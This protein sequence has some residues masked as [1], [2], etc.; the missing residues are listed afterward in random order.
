MNRLKTR[1]GTTYQSETQETIKEKWQNKYTRNQYFGVR[2]SGRNSEPWIV[3]LCQGRQ[4]AS[5]TLPT[6]LC[7]GGPFTSVLYGRQQTN[8]DFPSQ[9]EESQSCSSW[10]DAAHSQLECD[11]GGGGLQQAKTGVQ[12]GGVTLFRLMCTSRVAH[13]CLKPSLP[14]VGVLFLALMTHDQMG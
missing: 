5:L 11:W 10:L 13:T 1:Q 6:L 3:L 4:M 8:L 14:A 12:K 2:A 9:T 7:K